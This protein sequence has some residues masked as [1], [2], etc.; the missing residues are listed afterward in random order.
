MERGPSDN[1]LRRSSGAA[2]RKPTRE[3]GKQSRVEAEFIFCEAA[4]SRRTPMQL[5]LFVVPIKNVSEAEAEMNG[6]LHGHR[7]RRQLE[8]Q[9]QQRSLC[10]P[11][12]QQHWLP[13]CPVPSSTR[14]SDD[15]PADPA[16]VPSANHKVRGK[17][18][19][20][21]RSGVSIRTHSAKAPGLRF[22][23]A[24]TPSTP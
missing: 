16:T 17:D 5:E 13:G 11:Q 6:F 14:E 15:S 24:S 22:Q 7:V 20:L 21:P 12:R 10:Q 9:R 23:N 18:T 19:Q 4:R 3:T 1:C 2:N 8:Q